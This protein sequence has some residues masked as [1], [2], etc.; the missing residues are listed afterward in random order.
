MSWSQLLS[1]SR[2][3]LRISGTVSRH[4]RVSH[5]YIQGCHVYIQVVGEDGTPHVGSVL[6]ASAKDQQIFGSVC[7]SVEQA[8]SQLPLIL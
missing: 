4:L 5:V 7:W 2:K 6:C 1:N 3:K 8:H